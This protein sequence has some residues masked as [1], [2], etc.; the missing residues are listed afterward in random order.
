MDVVSFFAGCGGLDLGFE[1]AGFRVVW[2][3]DFD[4]C[5]YNTYERNHPNTFLC[6]DDINKI[7]PNDI[8]DCDGFIGG[9]P[10]QSWSVA[11]RRQGIE[12]KRGQLF[13]KYIAFIKAKMPK[14]F[15]IENVKGLLDEEFQD[16]FVGFL[17]QLEGIGYDVKYRL[18]DAAD[19]NVPQNRERVFIVGFR[20]DTGIDYQFPQPSSSKQ[21]T[22]KD[23]IGDINDIPIPCDEHMK[24]PSCNSYFRGIF[25]SYYYRGNRR[26]NWD[27]PSFTIHATGSNIP[28][29][30][31]SPKMVYK[32]HED[33]SF[34]QER[35][36]DYRRLTIRECARIQT[37]PDSFEIVCDNILD[38]YKMIGNA[39]P[40]K[41][42]EIIATSIKNTIEESR[43]NRRLRRGD[44]KPKDRVLVGYYKDDSQW[45]NIIHQGFYFVRTDGRKGS[46]ALEDLNPLPRLL[47]LHSGRKVHLFELIERRPMTYDSDH[48]NRLGFKP[49]GQQYI[50]VGFES[51]FTYELDS[52]GIDID[53]I[54][55]K[56]KYA[57]YITTLNKL[58]H[59]T[60]HRHLRFIDLFAGLGGF[61]FALSELGHQ[62]VFA[63]ELREDLR[64]LYQVNFPGTFIDGDITKI[65]VED[66]PAHDILC[67]GFP[68]QPFSQAGKRQ[69]FNDE[70]NRGNL[71]TY[72]CKILE[73]HHPQY[74]LLENVANLKGHDGG[75]TWRT[76]KQ[77][78]NSLDYDV[79][80]PAILSPHE[81]GIPQHR[82]RIYIVCR[83]RPCGDLSYFKYPVPPQK[84]KCD[85]QQIIDEN[86]TDF[87]KLKQDTREQLVLWQQF[88]DLIVAHNQKIPRFP[89]WAM[90]F[91]ADYEYKIKAPAFQTLKE[92]R[93]KHG[94]LGRI[95]NGH[96]KLECLSCLP[97]Y[98]QTNKTKVFPEWKIKYI[99]QNREFY[100]RNREW[101]DPWIEQVKD[102]ENSHLKLEWNCGDDATP[103]LIDKIIQFRASGIR[104]KLPTFS[105]ALNLVGTQIPIFPWIKLP[106]TAIDP[107]EPNFG[108]YMTRKE[109]SRLQGMDKL[110]FEDDNFALSVP[111]SFE[112]LG[113]AVNVELVKLIAK[114][115][116]R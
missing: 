60:T 42:A 25:G 62:C 39:V 24:M 14:F 63:S 18:L 68:C 34:I 94:H 108:R 75:N 115:L 38:A 61:H 6:K 3:N 33:W 109:A 64:Q 74:V 76:I 35:M 9:P 105:P 57:P 44:I 80:E 92:L 116:I 45:K 27:K 49:L 100:L 17:S 82:R 32:S 104:V 89:I 73:H 19:Y 28:L 51:S 98:A 70:K 102:L 79:A 15:L 47:L 23:A 103:T 110:K 40:V 66:I 97:I 13:L 53:T 8:P 11:G 85:I 46:I 113:N 1:Q 2:A 48:I 41:M 65:K 20:H 88:I 55:F 72:I 93:G 22:L 12:D 95:I 59:G 10:C 43:S 84:T 91:G 29:H 71:F 37:F 90:E 114:E 96:N 7:D 81:W 77:M 54:R 99:E 50:A 78:L 112:A 52:V 58:T 106:Q 101:L 30:P 31:N 87:I 26:R 5:V 16:V 111:R 67:A 69:G 86:D 21:L 83:Y 4:P 56:K 107:G 36:K